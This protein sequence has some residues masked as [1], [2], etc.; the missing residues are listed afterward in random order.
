[1]ETKEIIENIIEEIEKNITKKLTIEQLAEKYYIS[2]VHL[3][4][5]FTFLFLMPLAEYIRQ[6]KMQ[7]SLEM[8]YETDK[9]VCEIAYDL[10]FGYESSFIRSFKREFGITPS[11]A[12]K[13][14]HILKIIPPAAMNNY[15]G[16]GQGILSDMDFV[17]L[18]KMRLIGKRYLI[19]SEDS[20]EMAPEVAKKFWEEDASR[21]TGKATEG[22]YIGYTRNVHGEAGYSFYMPSVPVTKRAQIPEG[23][24]AEETEVTQAVRFRYIGHHHYY[25][26]NAAVADVMYQKIDAFI[27]SL[28]EN[29][30]VPYDY[31][32]EKID[33]RDY[34]GEYCM[35]EWYTPVLFRN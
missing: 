19:P 4:R 10:S 23:F 20:L 27:D 9:K 32:F 17:M 1:M 7:K 33:I 8:L 22:V 11:E 29:I 34:D 28:P 26:L 5:I 3:Q 31:Y 25:D 2:T 18:P 15:S 16:I 24:I 13:K 30:V 6:R 14:M 12:R 21:I 35:M